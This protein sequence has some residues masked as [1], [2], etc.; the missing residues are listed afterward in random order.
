M[1]FSSPNRSQRITRTFT[2][3]GFNVGK[4]PEDLWASMISYYNNNA[5]MYH[6]EEWENKGVHVNWWE[7]DAHMIGMPWRLKGYWQSRL[8][9]M[10]EAW[11]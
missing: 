4:V 10:V 11:S 1:P 2:E 9:K 7:V 3:L 8:M 6:R 5:D